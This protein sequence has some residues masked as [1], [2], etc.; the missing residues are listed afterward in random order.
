MIQAFTPIIGL[1]IILVAG[2]II[3]R[4]GTGG[5]REIGPK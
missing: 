2:I 3:C 1:I 4:G 5:D